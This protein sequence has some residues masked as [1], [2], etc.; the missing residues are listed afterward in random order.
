MND[1]ANSVAFSETGIVLTFVDGRSVEP[2]PLDVDAG[3]SV[4]VVATELTVTFGGADGTYTVTG[5][6]FDL[7]LPASFVASQNP[8]LVLGG[9][10]WLDGLA[11]TVG[12]GVHVAN[13]DAPAL[14]A[15]FFDGLL[16]DSRIDVVPAGL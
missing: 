7:D 10:T 6:D 13:S 14:R 2:L 1:C 12:P 11:A 9:N 15:A 4:R 5:Q 3:C 8:V 16:Q